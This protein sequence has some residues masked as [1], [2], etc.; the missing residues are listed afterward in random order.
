MRRILQITAVTLLTAIFLGLFL[1]KANLRDVWNIMRAA[2][3]GWIIVGL[4]VNFSALVFRAVRWRILIDPRNPPP[5]YPTFFATVVGYMMSTV[6]P[7]RAGDVVRPA[8]LA[9]RTTVRFGDALGPVLTERV[10]DFIT[11]LSLFVGFCAYRWKQF[12][13]AAVHGGAIAAGALLLALILFV[14]GIVLF[15]ERIRR[16][17]RWIG[18]IVPLRFRDAWMRFFDSFARS[19]DIRLQPGALAVVIVSTAA[20]WLCLVSQFWFVMIAM[21][22]VLPF[23]STIFLCAVTA[24]AVAI[25]TPGGVGGFH[26][27]CQWVLTTF[28]GYD[29]DTS[30]A[31]AVL[32][33]VVGMTPVVV[34]G[35]ILF[36]REGLNWRELSQETHAE[37]T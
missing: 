36:L 21:R 9:R 8:L 2:N 10:L 24:V 34:A 30:V 18:R 19:L 3:A 27:V 28:Y 22:R 5:F 32:F 1:W 6:L 25:P 37:E 4:T 11:I 14:I 16:A 13:N 7:I 31:A 35:V 26:K 33:H 23:D 15:T 29:I 17:H 12:D 20:I